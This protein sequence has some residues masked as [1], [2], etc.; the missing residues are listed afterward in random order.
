[1]VL[2]LTYREMAYIRELLQK[3]NPQINSIDECLRKA[4]LAKLGILEREYKEAL[5]KCK[6]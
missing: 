2:G 6:S 5:A 1:M 3:A 4:I